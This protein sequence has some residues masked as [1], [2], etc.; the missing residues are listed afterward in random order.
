MVGKVVCRA[1]GLL[2]LVEESRIV[3]CRPE[4]HFSVRLDLTMK[5]GEELCCGR[6]MR[7]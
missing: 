6:K 4:G 1:T 2:F 5:R 7:H 3:F